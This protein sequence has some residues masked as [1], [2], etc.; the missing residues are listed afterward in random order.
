MFTIRGDMQNKKSGLFLLI[1]IL[2][3][4]GVMNSCILPT[5]LERSNKVLIKNRVKLDKPFAASSEL[6]GFIQQQ[7]NTK[8]LGL[9]RFNLW[10][11]RYSSKG[12]E[13]WLKRWLNKSVAEPP[14]FL[15]TLLTEM[16]A[17]KMK[18]YLNNVGYFNSSVKKHFSSRGH[19]IIATYHVET[20]TP[21]TIRKINYVIKDSLLQKIVQDNILDG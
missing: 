5:K 1:V 10:V 14:V 19:K 4:T 11:H 8:L 20:G 13:G 21:Y 16:G 17:R 15:D 2:I 12:E 7:P 9:F 3:L 6:S 18:L